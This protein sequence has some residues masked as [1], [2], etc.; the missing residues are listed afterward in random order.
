MGAVREIDDLDELAGLVTGEPMLYLRYSAGPERDAR[1][2]S[3]D[4]E[5][6]VD[7]PGLPA[8]TLRPEDWWTRPAVDWVARRVC[9]YLD[10]ARA[11]PDRYPW[12]LTGRVVGNGPDHEP[13]LTDV[14]PVARLTDR[15][16]DQARSHYE[17]HFDV[18]RAVPG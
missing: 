4:Y 9:K 6:G 11:E 7:L 14:R 12:L 8:T 17:R 5:A 13:L 10:L 2:P 3:R 16:L 18:G 1:R 15:L